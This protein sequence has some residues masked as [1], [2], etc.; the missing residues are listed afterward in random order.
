MLS[1]DS[2]WALPPSSGSSWR[3]TAVAEGRVFAQESPGCWMSTIKTRI[4]CFIK[5]QTLR[6]FFWILYLA[7][8]PQANSFDG[9]E[10]WF[11]HL[12]SLGTEIVRLLL[13]EYLP[14][15]LLRRLIQPDPDDNTN[16][17]GQSWRWQDFQKD[18]ASYCHRHK[19]K[20]QEWRSMMT[21]VIL[22]SSSPSRAAVFSFD[23]LPTSSWCSPRAAPCRTWKPERG[24][25][26]KHS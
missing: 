13:T 24:C 8:G 23:D 20:Q 2:F 17:Q 6:D 4:K 3:T 26:W 18:K 11:V 25:Q 9:F 16:E 19:S 1:P 7:K 14:H 10:L 5:I 22:T 12:G 21:F 15:L